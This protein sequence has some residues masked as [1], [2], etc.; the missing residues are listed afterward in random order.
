[1]AGGQN[2]ADVRIAITGRVLTAPLGSTAPADVAAGWAAAWND[3]G[4]VDPGGVGKSPK[5]SS[6][7]VKAWQADSAVRTRIVERG[8]DIQFKLIQSGG[9]NTQLYYGGGSWSQVPTRSVSDGVLN[10]TTTYVSATAT[11]VTGDVGATIAGVGIPAGTTI[12]SRTNGT[13][14]IMSAAATITA[15]GVATTIGAAGTY[16]YTPP[17]PGTDDIRMLGIEWTD[18]AITKREIYTN[19]IVSSVGTATLRADGEL[20]YDITFTVNGDTYFF[21]SNDP[22]D[23]PA[24]LVA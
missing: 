6:Y 9:L 1:M 5:I 16:R 11:F 4:L 2:A 23:N 24:A 19:V 12:V 21:L 22:A 3:H 20:Q 15:T 10:G 7:A 18:G 14:V 13:T 8:Q 17:T